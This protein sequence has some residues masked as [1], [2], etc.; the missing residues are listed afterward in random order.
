MFNAPAAPEPIATANKEISDDDKST[1]EGAIKRPT[2]QVNKTRDITLGFIR[3]KNDC[4]LNAK[5]NLGFL[6]FIIIWLNL[7]YFR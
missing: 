7:F 5:L 2:M 3:L 4:K 6:D 1:F